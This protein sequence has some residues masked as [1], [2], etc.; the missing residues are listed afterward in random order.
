MMIVHQTPPI[1]RSPPLNLRPAQKDGKFKV[2]ALIYHAGAKVG[3]KGA[4]RT[5]ASGDVQGTVR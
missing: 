1:S 4:E 2:K 5:A 3:Q